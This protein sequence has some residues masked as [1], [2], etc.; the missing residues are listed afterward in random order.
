MRSSKKVYI[1]LL[2]WNGWQDTLECL[3]SVFR[4]SYDDFQVIVCDNDSKDGSIEKIKAW[5]EGALNPTITNM[6]HKEFT[7]PPVKKPIPYIE[8][9]SAEEAEKPNL[10]KSCKPLILI[11]TG[12]NLGFAGGNNVGLRYALA[13]GDFSYIWLLNNDTVIKKDALLHMVARMNKQKTAGIC[14]STLLYYHTPYLVQARAGAVY[15]KWKCRASEIDNGTAASKVVQA[16]LIENQL[17]YVS[18]ASMLVSLDFLKTVGLMAEDY[19][20]YFEEFDWAQRAGNAYQLVYA[21]DSIVY[22]KEGG[23]IGTKSGKGRSPLSSYFLQRNRIKFVQRFFRPYLPLLFF[24]FA[25]ESINALRKKNY[26]E[27]VGI[28][29]AL[30]RLQPKGLDATE[31]RK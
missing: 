5:A 11:R 9:S 23:S 26:N 31:S 2:N 10:N 13:R 24:S 16:E 28:V 3:E 27:F 20:L 14:G 29:R 12:G 1:L 21:P 18:G 4:N 30:L 15:N 19:F 6:M 25:M 22:H 7:V 17:A 8:V